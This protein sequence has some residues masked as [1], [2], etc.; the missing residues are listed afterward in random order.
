MTDLR[1][2]LASNVR[3]Y[4]K[5]LGLSQGGLAEKADTATN[6]IGMIETGKKF[7][8]IDM[9]ERLAEALQTDTLELFSIKPVPVDEALKNL[10]KDILAE[11]EQL[12]ANRFKK[13]GR[14]Q[15]DAHK[16]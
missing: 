1:Q 15:G 12:I 10:R 2:V 11:V 14:D 9:I 13:F 8:S 7:P 6:Y 16:M 3:Q 4:R 5:K